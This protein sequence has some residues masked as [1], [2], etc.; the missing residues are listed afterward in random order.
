MLRVLVATDLS[1]GSDH[2]LS[3]ALALASTN[4][5]SVRVV[6]VHDGA[7]SGEE[8]AT[9]RQRLLARSRDQGLPG[10]GVEVE[11]R[12]GPPAERILDVAGSFMADLIVIGAHGRMRLRDAWLGTTATRLLR[13]AHAPLLVVHA[14][15]VHPYRRILAAVDDTSA[16][17]TVLGLAGQLSSAI[18]V[19]AV[20]AFHVPYEA[21]AEVI[22]P[23]EEIRTDHE[24]AIDSIVCKVAPDVST[25]HFE[26]IVEEGDV[27][28]VIASAAKR[29][30]PDLLL[31]GTH[32]R[33][34]LARILFGSTAEAA[35]AYFDIDMLIVRT[36][37]SG[38]L[39]E[40]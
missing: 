9:I 8:L 34:G 37:E 40:S 21:Y 23:R 18:E 6:H 26:S 1:P 4:K 38:M 14:R 22:A 19:F 2:A 13:S 31:L 25:L 33:R 17:V 28:S 3:R 39:T 36:G 12:S 11:F 7:A 24:R 29:V 15:D 16:A 35:L 5:A 32:G 30:S 10:A 27:L 20:H